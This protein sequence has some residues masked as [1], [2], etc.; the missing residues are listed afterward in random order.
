MTR[1]CGGT[2]PTARQFEILCW[3]ANTSRA[4]GYAPSL[5]EIGRRFGISST[6]GVNDHLQ[7]LTRKGL[8][9]AHP[10][11]HERALVLTETGKAMV[12]GPPCAACDGTGREPRR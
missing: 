11:D 3:I 7:A 4:H 2:T 8:L 1:I 6:N 9:E 12:F 5:R 10:K